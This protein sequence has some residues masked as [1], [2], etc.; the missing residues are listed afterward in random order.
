MY[1]AFPVYT[2][3]LFKQL[4]DERKCLFIEA[5]QQVNE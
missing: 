1:P 4:A 3:P 2:V 5:F